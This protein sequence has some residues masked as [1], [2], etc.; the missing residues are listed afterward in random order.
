MLTAAHTRQLFLA[1]FSPITRVALYCSRK[2]EQFLRSDNFAYN[3]IHIFEGFR[4]LHCHSPA[5]CNAILV[6]RVFSK[7]VSM[8]TRHV[9]LHSI[10]SEACSGIYNI[11]CKHHILIT[12]IVTILFPDCPTLVDQVLQTVWVKTHRIPE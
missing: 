12:L 9:L 11:I 7:L 10:A 5:L 8:F 6:F 4:S 1:N 2:I 3:D